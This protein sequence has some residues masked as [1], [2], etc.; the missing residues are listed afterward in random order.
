M[1]F[2][3]RGTLDVADVTSG[4]PVYW[5]Q[6]QPHIAKRRGVF[7]GNLF[8]DRE[9]ATLLVAIVKDELG[10]VRWASSA[11]FGRCGVFVPLVTPATPRLDDGPA[12]L[13]R[14]RTAPCG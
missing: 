10:S 5:Q 1:R 13:L 4:T 3:K 11:L 8:Q 14:L 2:A 7:A 9:Q 6:P 12:H